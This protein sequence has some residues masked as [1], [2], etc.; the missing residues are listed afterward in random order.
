MKTLYIS[1]LDGTLLNPDAEISDKTAQVLNRLIREDVQFTVATA[2]TFATVDQILTPVNINL[3]IVLMNGA[4]I[5]DTNAKKYIHTEDLDHSKAVEIIETIQKHGLSLLMYTIQDDRMSTYFEP[6]ISSLMQ[7]YIDLR[8]MRYNK[9]FHETK[10]LKATCRNESVYF[11]TLGPKEALEAAA[12]ALQQLEG[13]QVEFYRDVYSD[14]IWMEEIWFLEVFKGNASKESAV[15]FLKKTFGFEKVISFGD[16]YNDMPMFHASDACY[17][18]GNAREE[19]KATATAVIGTNTENGVARWLDQRLTRKWYKGNLHC[20]S[21][22][23]DGKEMPEERIRQY[24]DKGYDFL[25]LTDHNVYG[26]TAYTL[27]DDFLLIRGVERDVF[28]TG[29]TFKVFHLIGFEGAGGGPPYASGERIE[30]LEWQGTQTVQKLID[31]M[32]S[33]GNIVF[34]AHPIW[35]RNELSDIIALQGLTGVEVY[36]HN[37][38]M[39]SNDGLSEVYWDSLLRRGRLV[40]GFGVDDTHVEQDKF[41]GW[42]MVKAQA[43]TVSAIAEAIQTGHFYAS[44]GPELFDFYVE[45]QTVFVTCSPANRINFVMYDTHGHSCFAKGMPLTEAQH[46]LRGTETYVRVEIVDAQGKKAWSNPI[47]LRRD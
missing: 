41:G 22:L 9:G 44:T 15:Q 31:E 46:K 34:L 19:V 12:K 37:C 27:P 23:S 35:S 28:V 25:S 21:T 13:V 24:K 18:V 33:H 2:R 42:I 6:P 32:K 45:N 47:F 26:T 16:N 17:A 30:K 10:S 20:H 7:R 11:S 14:T 3:P 4:A 29:E 39:E 1:D 40:W 8:K 36:N 5:Y 43:L 38:N